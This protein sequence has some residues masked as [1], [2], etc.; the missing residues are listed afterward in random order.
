MNKHQQANAEAREKEKAERLNAARTKVLGGEIT[1]FSIDT[2]IFDEKGNR[3]N[4]GVFKH[5]EQF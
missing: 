4:D 2:C 1:A 3:L 5:L